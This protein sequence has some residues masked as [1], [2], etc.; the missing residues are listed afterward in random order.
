MRIRVSTTII[1]IF[2]NIDFEL[3][4]PIN[5]LIGRF[6]DRVSIIQQ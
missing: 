3:R 1:N 2:N 6:T 4:L 5:N